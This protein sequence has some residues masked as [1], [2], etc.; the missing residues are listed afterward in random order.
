M[1]GPGLPFA[2]NR[3]H[4][5]SSPKLSSP[6][7]QSGLAPG[8]SSPDSVLPLLVGRRAG[9]CAAGKSETY[10]TALAWVAANSQK[11]LSVALVLV[12]TPTRLLSCSRSGSP[13]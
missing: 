1:S 4:L 3:S 12:R 8:I 2:L 11:D 6:S 5:G 7:Q 13:L 10:S 9:G